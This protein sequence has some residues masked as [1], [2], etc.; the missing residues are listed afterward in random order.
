MNSLYMVR[1]FGTGTGFG[2]QVGLLILA[3]ALTGW[4]CWRRRRGDYG[5]VLLA[6]SLTWTAVELALQLAGMRV[7]PDR[8]LL[9]ISLPL[10]VS[11]PLQGAAEGGAIAVLGLFVGD[12]LLCRDTR[13]AAIGGLLGLCALAVVPILLYGETVREVTSRRDI[14]AVP[15]ILFCSALLATDVVLWLRWPVWRRRAVAMWTALLAIGTAWTIAALA[16]GG[17]WIEVAGSLPG[18]YTRANVVWQALGLGYDVVVEIACAYVAF[19]AVPAMLGVL[20]A[21]ADAGRCN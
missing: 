10:L 4:D 15:S 16:A 7:M 13:T 11:A 9:G 17:R 5:W 19:L 3:L 2:P 1:D 6:G 18:T 12:R 14:L 21:D 20:S 8:T